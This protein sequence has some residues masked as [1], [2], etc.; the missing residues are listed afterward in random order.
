[1]AEMVIIEILTR[2]QK[3]IKEEKAHQY[4]TRQRGKPGL[5]I[6][7]HS[8]SPNIS[9]RPTRDQEATCTRRRGRLSRYLRVLG[10]DDTSFSF[11]CIR[12]VRALVE[13]HA[14]LRPVD[15]Y[16]GLSY[17]ISMITSKLTSNQQVHADT[18]HGMME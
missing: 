2:R 14:P 5:Q 15:A 17:G 16:E 8:A 18:T 12:A 3:R 1:M 9:N 4:P 6:L 11:H 7:H 13:T 10:S